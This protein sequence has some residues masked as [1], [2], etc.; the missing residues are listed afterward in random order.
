MSENMISVSSGS[1]DFVFT[2]SE[3]DAIEV[4]NP[5]EKAF[6]VLVHHEKIKGK[7]HPKAYHKKDL[8]VEMDGE[9]FDIKIKDKLDL[10]LQSM[11]LNTPKATKLKA[12]KAPM[13]GLVIEINVE[14]GQV[15][16]EGQKILILE[17]MKMENVIK[18]PH[19]A[20][21]GKVL[22]QKG[23]AVDKGQTLI[24]LA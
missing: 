5:S 12:L 9:F 4:I 2:Q 7:I 8:E 20:V 6:A 3:I 21:I 1:Y 15:V 16:E 17:A 22:I 19:G 18:I 24:E 13:P 23:Q 11:G 14:E 10:L